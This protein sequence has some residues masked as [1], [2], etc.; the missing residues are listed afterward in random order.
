MVIGLPEVQ[1][2]EVGLGQEILEASTE[3]TTPISQAAHQPDSEGFGGD[4]I[5]VRPPGKVVETRGRS[6]SVVGPRQSERQSNTSQYTSART[7]ADTIRAMLAH[8]EE[9]QS[10]DEA[11]ARDDSEQWYEAWESEVDSLVRNETWVLASLPAGRKA[12]GCRWLLKWK[13]D[14]CYK[15]RLV[16][17]GYNQKAGV[18]YTETFAP[19]AKFNSLRTLLALVCENDWE[20]E[21]MDVKTAFLHSAL[22]ETV[23]ME[24]PEGLHTEIASSNQRGEERIVCR[25]TKSIYGLKQSPRTWYGKINKFFIDHGFQRSEHDHNVYIHSIFKLIL[26]LYVDDLVITAPNSEDVSWIQTILHEE[27][28]MT[29]LGPL[30]SFLGLELEIQRNR[31]TRMLHLSQSKYIGTILE[32]HSMLNCA[33]VSTPADPHVRLVKSIPEQQSDSYNQQRYQSAVGSLMYAM[34]GSRPDI[35]FA[36]SAVSQYSTNPGPTHWTA[37][38]RIFRYLSGTRS[39]GLMYGNGYCEGYTDADWGASEDRKSIGGYTFLINGAS[40]SWASKKQASVALSSTKAEFMALTEGPKEALWL[41]ELLGDL[42][43]L[44]HRQEIQKLVCDNQG[45]IALTQNPEYHARTKHIDIR[46]HFIRQHVDEGSIELI[47][48]PTHENTADIFTKP[49]PRPQFEKHVLGLG[50][51]PQEEYLPLGG[52]VSETEF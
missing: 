41:G 26:L 22:E 51:G 17:K 2:K 32:R 23:F 28:E 18:D 43:A 15:A 44:K 48:C 14:G 27:F 12:I 47:Y 19:V 8:L 45:A 13:E 10:L 34:I 3:D 42:G 1:E 52:Q 16:A 7:S 35:A 46:Y 39:H 25:L 5:I 11:L 30:T 9:P 40:V 20:L 38:R 36:V 33:L 29:E 31:K 24:I 4:T 49:L 37:V 50:L 21:G 6:V